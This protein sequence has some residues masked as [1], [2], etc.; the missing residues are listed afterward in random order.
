LDE[1]CRENVLTRVLL[2]MIQASQPIDFAVDRVTHLRRR[3]LNYMQDTLVFSVNAINYAGAAK[4]TRVCGLPAARRIEGGAIQRDRDLT[5][6]E[7][8]ETE[9]ARIEFEEP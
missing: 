6:I 1:S 2:Q 4:R 3:S 8:A 7:L 5:V 9:Y